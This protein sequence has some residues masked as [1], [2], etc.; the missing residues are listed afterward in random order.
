MSE[1]KETMGRG[2]IGT[3]ESIVNMS[4]VGIVRKRRG[5]H[6]DLARVRRM[7]C[8]DES[9]G[10]MKGHSNGSGRLQCDV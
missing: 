5:S 9:M 8:V 6:D 10:V 1:T 3:R 2:N 4:H 7:T